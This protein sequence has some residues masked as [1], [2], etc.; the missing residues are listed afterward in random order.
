MS[1]PANID[2]I[3]SVLRDQLDCARTEYETERNE[4]TISAFTT[5][6]KRFFRFVSNGTLPAEF[7]LARGKKTEPKSKRS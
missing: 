7:K 2:Q 4:R 3:A 6:S 5:A 1:V